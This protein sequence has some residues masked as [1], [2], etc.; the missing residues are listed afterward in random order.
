MNSS[1]TISFRYRTRD[2]VRGWQARFA[3][4]TRLK[5][6]LT[7]ALIIVVWALDLTYGSR[8]RLEWL[9][10]SLF[11]TVI[12]LLILGGLAF[13]S[14]V[15]RL[16]FGMSARFREPYTVTFSP[17]G[18]RVQSTHADA[19]LDWERFS[20]AIFDSEAYILCYG[21]SQF[22]VIP[23]RAFPTPQERQAV[24]QMLTRFVLE[25]VKRDL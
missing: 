14:V 21:R 15:P 23:K 16:I 20:R 9:I 4:R 17:E 3:S 8:S 22:G 18:I 5:E 6:H 13:R 24:E 10:F 19:K 12:L 7:F 25:T 2:F 11:A 1:I